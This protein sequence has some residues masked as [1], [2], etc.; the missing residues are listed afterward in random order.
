VKQ[1]GR[2]KIEAQDSGLKPG[3]VVRLLQPFQPERNRTQ[4]YTLAIVVGVVEHNF[5][6]WQYQ[7][8]SDFKQTTEVDCSRLNEI[9]VYLCEP[10]S[11][12]IYVDAYGAQA[13][14][15]FNLDEVEL[16]D[17]RGRSWG[18]SRSKEI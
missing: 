1:A 17:A 9:V 16:V 14:F 3:D 5:K 11:L 10:Q 8:S 15:S 2:L 18:V 13:L 7:V 12:N 6:N 4:E